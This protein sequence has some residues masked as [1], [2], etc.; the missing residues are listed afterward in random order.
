MTTPTVAD[1]SQAHNPPI[2]PR[3]IIVHAVALLSFIS[4]IGYVVLALFTGQGS[5]TLINIAL[6]GLSG[7]VGMAMPAHDGQ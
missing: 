7:L 6:S 3:R 4:I 1:R 2:V 5:E